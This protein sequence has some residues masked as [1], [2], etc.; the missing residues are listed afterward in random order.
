MAKI[1]KTH[2]LSNTSNQKNSSFNQ[3]RPSNSHRPK[4]VVFKRLLDWIDRCDLSSQVGLPKADFKT[5][6]GENILPTG[7]DE[8]WWLTD[9]SKRILFDDKKE[10]KHLEGDEDGPASCD[11]EDEEP[12]KK[13]VSDDDPLSEPE[14]LDLDRSTA[15]SCDQ[16]RVSKAWNS[17]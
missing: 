11:E 14:Q 13:E 9:I 4:L 12:E 17:T 15:S 8:L 16:Y 2:H 3:T 7:E 5:S 10:E 1:D 6:D